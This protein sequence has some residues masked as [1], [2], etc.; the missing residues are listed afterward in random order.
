MKKTNYVANDVAIRWLNRNMTTINT[1][2]QLL[3]I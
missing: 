1:I 3:D 2:L